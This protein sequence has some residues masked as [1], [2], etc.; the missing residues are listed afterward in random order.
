MLT[1]Y[2]AVKCSEM[3]E[4][5]PYQETRRPP[6]NVPYLV[7]NIWEWLRP[8]GFPCR[9]HC[10]YASPTPELALACISVSPEQKDGFVVTTVTFHGRVAIAQLPRSD[11]KFHPDVK[12]LPKLILNFLGPEWTSQA[13]GNRLDM[14]PL[15]LP[16]VS[17]EEVEDALCKINGGDELREIIIAN[18]RFWQDAVLLTHE[19]D[20]LSHPEGELF[21]EPFDGYRLTRTINTKN[22]PAA[23]R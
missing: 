1:L 12:A 11:A 14:A 10:A 17:K 21:F 9:R 18:S 23:V 19:D 6:G 20:T 5:N 3:Q 13:V 8:E 15:F 22:D 4:E 2:R 16:A 7:D